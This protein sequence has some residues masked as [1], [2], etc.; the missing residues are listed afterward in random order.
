[1]QTQAEILSCAVPLASDKLQIAEHFGSAPYFYITTCRKKDGKLL[2][3]S[4]LHNPFEDEMPKC[5]VIIARALS[6]WLLEK[7]L[8]IAYAPKGFKGRGP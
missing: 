2:S 8:D 3:E 5:E 7:G 4:Y 6:E 1:V